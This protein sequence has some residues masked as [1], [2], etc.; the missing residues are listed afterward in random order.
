[1]NTQTDDIKV[2]TIM[3]S[4]IALKVAVMCSDP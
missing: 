4:Y 3:L 1:M 2:I